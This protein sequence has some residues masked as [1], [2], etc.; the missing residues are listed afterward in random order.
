VG[1]VD[2]LDAGGDPSRTKATF[3]GAFV[4]RLVPSPIRASGFPP[5]ATH[6]MAGTVE[7]VPL[8]AKTG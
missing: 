8:A 2:E 5:S 1:R 4:S 3:S 7:V 6:A